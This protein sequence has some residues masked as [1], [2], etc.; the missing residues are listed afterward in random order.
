[1]NWL[2]ELKIALVSNDCDKAGA[3]IDNF[4]SN[5]ELA[6]CSLEE[7]EEAKEILAQIIEMLQSNQNQVKSQILHIKAAKK[8]LESY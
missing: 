2:N 7:L 6:K 3:V 5:E 1:M 8:F 4:P